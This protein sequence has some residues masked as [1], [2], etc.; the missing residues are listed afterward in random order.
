M[1]RPTTASLKRVTPE[2]LATLGVQRLAA[3][4]VAASEG[5]PELKRRLRMELAAEQ[6]ADHLAPEID[7]RWFSGDQSGQDIL[8]ATAC[9]R[10]R[11]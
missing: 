7:K 9:L 5:R 6:G 4:L 2:N 11:R 10:P 1:K 3:I 8:A